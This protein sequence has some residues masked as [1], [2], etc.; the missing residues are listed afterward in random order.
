LSESEA[1]NMEEAE[2]IS[3]IKDNWA[4]F[5]GS[6]LKQLRAAVSEIATV[7]PV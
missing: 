4:Q 3:T 1:E 7:A 2:K 6:D 5:I